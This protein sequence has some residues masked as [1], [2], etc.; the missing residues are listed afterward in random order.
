MAAQTENPTTEVAVVTEPKA[1]G[2]NLEKPTRATLDAEYAKIDAEIAKCKKVMDDVKQKIEKLKES[3]AS[4][5]EKNKADREILETLRAKSAE[6]RAQRAKAQEAFTAALEKK[7]ALY[8]KNDQSKKSLDRQAKTVE[9]VEQKIREREYYLTTSSLTLKEEKE[10]HAEMKALEKSK[11]VIGE[12]E[13]IQIKKTA[14]E[15]KI[16][17]LKAEADAVN[18]LFQEAIK[19]EQ[20]QFEKVQAMRPKKDNDDY[21]KWSEQRTNA[22]VNM[23]ALYLKK[24]NLGLEFKKKE[25][26]FYEHLRE[27]RKEQDERRKAEQEARKEE[28]KMRKLE[29][30]EAE[31][32]NMFAKEFATIDQLSTYLKAFVV[33]DKKEEA[34]V[35]EA[36]KYAEGTVLIGKAARGFDED[37]FGTKK[38]GKGKKSGG[39]KKKKA[40]VFKHDLGLVQEFEMLKVSAPLTQ[41][42]VPAAIK[43]L[44][45]RKEQLEKEKETKHAKRVAKIAEMKNQKDEGGDEAAGDEAAG[46]EAAEEA[47]ANAAEAGMNDKEIIEKYSG[48]YQITR[49]DLQLQLIL[50]EDE[51]YLEFNLRVIVP[52]PDNEG[53]FLFNDTF[54]DPECSGRWVIKERVIC[55]Y[56]SAPKKFYHTY[57][58]ASVGPITWKCTNNLEE[59]MVKK[60]HLRV[61]EP[62]VEKKVVDIGDNFDPFDML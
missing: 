38:A 7:K 53:A 20:A 61:T 46:D 60:P 56:G 2:K 12:M 62:K 42:E 25:N 18:K 49:G 51:G 34:Q 48:K 39:G 3:N 5:K 45:D 30:E 27:K 21:K 33:G 37:I 44:A 26:E 29:K 22:K 1:L 47:A 54:N 17:E 8:V 50:D 4:N 9:Q 14:Q 58:K 52:N 40:A 31:H 24:R 23:D 6:L 13:A 41:D 57:E 59:T 35:V 28:D 43:A 36:P 15:A 55:L 32:A 11:K 19:V 16:K 10:V